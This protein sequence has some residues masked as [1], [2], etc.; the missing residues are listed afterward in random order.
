MAFLVLPTAPEER[1][2]PPSRAVDAHTLHEPLAFV[3]IFLH[4]PHHLPMKVFFHEYATQ[5]SDIHRPTPIV[6]THPPKE[7]HRYHRS[8]RESRTAQDGTRS[9]TRYR[10]SLSR[11]RPVRDDRRGPSEAGGEQDGTACGGRHPP[12]GGGERRRQRR[13]SEPGDGPA[14]GAG[15]WQQRLAGPTVEE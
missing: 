1:E 10:T 7:A 14:P 5:A 11:P 9:R 8:C 15:R 2:K 13:R 3:D 12:D 4:L 6:L